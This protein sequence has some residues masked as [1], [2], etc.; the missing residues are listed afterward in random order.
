MASESKS[1]AYSIS[2]TAKTIDSLYELQPGDHI[3]VKEDL[4][5]SGMELLDYTHHMVVVKVLSDV[6]IKIIHKTSDRRVVEEVR[7]YR[8]EDIEVLDYECQYTGQAA[9]TRARARI[10]EEDYNP[11]WSNCEHFVTEVKTGVAQSV[12]VRDIVV[13]GAGIAVGLGVIGAAAAG[14]AYLFAPKR[15][16]NDDD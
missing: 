10:G 5:S 4:C 14:L 2:C 6:M 11:L 13:T 3:R 12:Q 9:I 16:D 15:K 7:H 1:Q 8:P